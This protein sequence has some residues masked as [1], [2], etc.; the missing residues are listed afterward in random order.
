M[1]NWKN[2]LKNSEKIRNTLLLHDPAQ[3]AQSFFHPDLRGY[4]FLSWALGVTKK[5]NLEAFPMGQFIASLA[6]YSHPFMH[7][8]IS[9]SLLKKQRFSKNTLSTPAP[10]Q[11]SSPSHRLADWRLESHTH[12]H[13]GTV[14]RKQALHYITADSL[15]FI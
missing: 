2:I 1:T 11:V 5:P 6:F 10:P 12:T 9:I 4:F 3:M 8:Y 13:R 7:T 15:A 14:G